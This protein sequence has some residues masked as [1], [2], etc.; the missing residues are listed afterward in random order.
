MKRRDAIR[1]AGCAAAMFGL[2]APA[3]PA[4]ALPDRS[5]LDRDPE[6]YWKRIRDEQFLL[7]GWRAF[8]NN[9]SLGIAPRPVLEAV[10]DFLTK[11]AGLDMDFYPR[12]G[13]ET[14]DEHRTEVAEFFG[15]KKDELAFTHNATE[16]MSFIGAGLDLKAGDEVLITDQEHPSGRGC[17]FMRQARHGITVREVKIELPPKNPGQVADA[18]VSAIGP[19]TRVLSFSSITTTTGLITPV[20]EICQAARAKG[21]ITVVDAAHMHGQIPFRISDLGCDFLAGS[22][23]KWVFAPAGSGFLYIRE[24]VQDR[25][26]PTVVTGSWDKKDLKAARYMMVGTNNRA[27]FEGMLAG[28]RFL[29]QLGPERVYSR[30]HQLGRKVLEQAR[31]L[32]YLELLTPDDDRMFGSLVTFRMQPDHFKKFSALCAKRKIW[33]VQ[34]ERLR[35]ATHIHTRPADIDLFFETLRAARS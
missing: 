25:F 24:E 7:P 6:A 16:A 15:C 14:L 12:W 28:L 26:W 27:I 20:R 19:R 34:S 5:L 17:W 32:P 10:T 21:V 23:H 3:K 4:T 35:V 1:A 11:S 33:I 30:I 13:Y 29:K 18:I 22:P 31:A 2:A 9:G 8:M